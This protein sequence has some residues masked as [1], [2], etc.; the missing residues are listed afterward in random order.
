MA[1]DSIAVMRRVLFLLLYGMTI[2]AVRTSGQESSKSTDDSGFVLGVNTFFDFGPPFNYYEIFVV[3][4]IAQGSKVEKFTLTPVAH[5]CYAPAKAEYAENTTSLSVKELLI[6]V[7]PCAIRDKDLKK[8]AKRKHKES[9]LSGANLS[10]RMNCGRNV[11]TIEMRVLER[12]WFLKHPGTPKN[13]DWTMQVLEKLRGSTGLGTMENPM[14]ALVG[15][16]PR[17]PLSAD[18]ASIENLRSG[19]GDVLFPWAIERE[20]VSAIYRESLVEPAKPS[21]T[22]V[23]STPIEPVQ[24][25]LPIYPPLVRMAQKEGDVSVVLTINAEGKVSNVGTYSGPKLLEGAMRDAV[26]DWKFP[27]AAEPVREVRV[28]VAFRLNC[29]DEEEKK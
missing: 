26:K 17:G 16:G 13:T 2:S 10:L 9:N 8:E 12:D 22:F 14:F 21:V 23:R 28:S 27:P 3:I 25:T 19:G 4:P 1:C 7:D 11:R 18:A 15:T 24:Y 6:G 20:K 5:K 29:S